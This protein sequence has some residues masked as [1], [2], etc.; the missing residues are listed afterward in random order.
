M[1]HNRK[2]SCA[3]TSNL[4]TI[5]HLINVSQPFKQG[6]RLHLVGKRQAYTCG[7]LFADHASGK[8]FNF[9]QLSNNAAKTITS[10]SC[11]D[12]LAIN[13]TIKIKSFHTN[14]DF[15]ALSAFK[16]DCT[17][18]KQKLIFSGVGAH[19]QNGVAECNIK[20]V[21]QWACTSML[22]AAHS[23]PEHANICLWPQAVDYTV[24]FFNHL[25][26][27]KN[28]VSPNEIWS[29]TR[30]PTNGLN[31]AHVF[32]CPVYVLDPRLQ[33]GHKIP[34]REPCARFGLFVGFLP[35]HLPLVPLVLNIQT[36]NI[37]PQYHVIF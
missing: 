24:W 8:I 1:E 7:T 9:C 26:S 15:F 14:S 2:F 29:C 28:G 18:K 3:D 33:D 37:S 32:G 19:H 17:L 34:K 20:T 12:T 30:F 21:S 13:K 5:S 4:A 31:S 10:K 16:E 36:G 25:P 23:W 11:L 22:H 27:I 6:F 35:L